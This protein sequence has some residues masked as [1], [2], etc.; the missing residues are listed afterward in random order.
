MQVADAETR[1]LT[2]RSYRGGVVYVMI[3]GPPLTSTYEMFSCSNLGRRP[4]I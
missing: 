2:I 3:D 1:Q 4:G